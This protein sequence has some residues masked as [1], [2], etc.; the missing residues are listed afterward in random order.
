[1]DFLIGFFC[2]GLIPILMW[3]GA[4]LLPLCWRLG[5]LTEDKWWGGAPLVVS[6]SGSTLFIL[7]GI[8]LVAASCAVKLLVLDT[9]V[10]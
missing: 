6:L 5:A 2:L 7:I 1:M 4:I 3:V 10:P 8:F 9:L